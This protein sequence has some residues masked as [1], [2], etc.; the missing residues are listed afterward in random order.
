ME[1]DLASTLAGLAYSTT[2]GMLVSRLNGTFLDG[3]ILPPVAP[4]ALLLL[5][6]EA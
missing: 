4:H 2:R 5:E 3:C 6:A 1:D